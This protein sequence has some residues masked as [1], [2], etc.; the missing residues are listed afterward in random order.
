[1][2]KHSVVKIHTAK[3]L[4]KTLEDMPTF[5]VRL[6]EALNPHKA[7]VFLDYGD[8]PGPWVRVGVN[9]TVYGIGYLPEES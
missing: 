8:T 4:T 3:K 1:M 7:Q 9:D 5:H 2:T 6:E